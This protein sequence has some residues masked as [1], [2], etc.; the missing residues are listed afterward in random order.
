MGTQSR[1]KTCGEPFMYF[2]IRQ[3]VVQD[4]SGDFHHEICEIEPDSCVTTAGEHVMH[5]KNGQDFFEC[6]S[7]GLKLKDFY[8]FHPLCPVPS[9]WGV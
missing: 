5:W 9:D 8:V 2:P 3:E 7:C 1:C 4:S 6:G